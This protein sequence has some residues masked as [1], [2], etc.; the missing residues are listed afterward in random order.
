[1]R[2]RI[3]ANPTDG[4][5]WM[6][7]IQPTQR[8][9]FPRIPPTAVGGWLKFSLRRLRRLGWRLD[10]KYPPTAVGGITLIAV[11]SRLD[12][13]YPPTAVGGI[14]LELLRLILKDH[15]PTAKIKSRRRGG[16]ILAGSTRG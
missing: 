6:I 10:F 1:M 15:K 9:T 8:L 4:S 16:R 7:K 14:P 2:Q 11:A 13:K 5:R 12:F 3:A